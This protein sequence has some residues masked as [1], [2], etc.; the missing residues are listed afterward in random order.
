V[1]S[2]RERPSHEASARGRSLKRPTEIESSS[3]V[4]SASVRE[5]VSLETRRRTHK[6]ACV[7]HQGHH[8]LPP[9]RARPA[10]PHSS[11]AA[12]RT[13][14]SH[15]TESRSSRQEAAQSTAEKLRISISIRH[16][17]ALV[18]ARRRQLRVSPSSELATASRRRALRRCQCRPDHSEQ[19]P[20]TAHLVPIAF[21][22]PSHTS[23][24]IAPQ[25][26]PPDRHA[27]PAA[28]RA[29]ARIACTSGPHG[30]PLRYQGIKDTGRHAGCRIPSAALLPRLPATLFSG[31]S[32]THAR[33]HARPTQVI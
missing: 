4:V 31:F 3:A 30:E 5:W 26:S 33:T 22:H 1:S 8:P 29:G 24:P 7:P 17:V 15:A 6:P 18:F 27:G 10:V 25:P 21:P 23:S 11:V 2:E 13:A 19:H 9:G 12:K 20:S 14:I 32:T 16:T 28:P